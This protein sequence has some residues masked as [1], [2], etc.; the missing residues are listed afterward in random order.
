MPDL[1]LENIQPLHDTESRE[2]VAVV[3]TTFNDTEFLLDALRSVFA[4]THAPKEVIVVDDGSDE[5]PAYLVKTFPSVMLIRKKNGGLASARNVGLGQATSRFICFLD[6][7]DRLKPNALAAGL[8]CFRTDPHAALVYGG[9]HRIDRNGIRRSASAIY[10]PPG[11]DPYSSLL[12][13]N[14]I[15]M[16]AT[17]LY[18]RD[19][20]IEIG[21]YNEHLRRGEDYELYLRIAQRFRIASHPQTVAEYR[22]HG[23]NISGDTAQMLEAILSIHEKHRPNNGYRLDFWLQ[24]RRNWYEWYTDGQ[25]TTWESELSKP[26]GVVSVRLRAKRVLKTF[27]RAVVPKHLRALVRGSWPP[28][29]G[30]INFGSLASTR[31]VSMNFGWERGTPV[32]RYYIENFLEKNSRDIKGRVLEIGDDFYSRRFGSDITQMDVLH[33]NSEDRKVTITGD[34]TV[35]GVLPEGEFDCI[36]FTQTLQ[37]V[38]DLDDAVER[39]HAALKPGGVL[40]LTVP[41]ISQIDRHDWG[42]NWAWS[43]TV[44]SVHRLFERVF[45]RGELKLTTYGNVFAAICFLTGAVLEELDKKDLDVHDPAYPVNITLRA[46]RV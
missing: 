37:L 20:L 4:Q 3:V 25:R 29:L 30:K 6:A 14:I 33:V 45:G 44:T 42:T 34:V 23:S 38:Y 17:V 7:D 41:G 13:G 2:S 5:S 27:V 8:A 22:W 32:D 43:F 11:A 18:Q 28:P 40:L 12:T 39:L 24:G 46:Q 19:V 36:I 35:R 10:T 26:P 21:G 16:H 31:P 9:H 1:E 15:G